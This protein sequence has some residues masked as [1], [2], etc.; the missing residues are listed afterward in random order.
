MSDTPKT[1][2]AVELV[3]PLGRDPFPN[4]QKYVKVDFARELERENIALRA[5]QQELMIV[6]TMAKAYMESRR[7]GHGI[8]DPL[9]HAARKALALIEAARKEAQ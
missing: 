5:A 6:A 8:E 9:W 7:Y 4:L 3:R 1:D 2:E